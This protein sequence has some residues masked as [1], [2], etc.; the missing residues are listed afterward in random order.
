MNRERQ[1]ASAAPLSIRL[2]PDTTMTVRFVSEPTEPRR[3]HRRRVQRS[4][5]H[6]ESIPRETDVRPGSASPDT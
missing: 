1:Q 3:R 2:G 6:G 5:Y 4:D